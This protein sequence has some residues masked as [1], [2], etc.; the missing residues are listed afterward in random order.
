MARRR[1]DGLVQPRVCES[2]TGGAR[3]SGVCHREYGSVEP[4]P[5]PLGRYTTTHIPQ[6]QRLNNGTRPRKSTAA[7]LLSP[8]SDSPQPHRHPLHHA[9]SVDAPP[10]PISPPALPPPSPPPPRSHHHKQRRLLGNT[11]ARRFRLDALGAAAAVGGDVWVVRGA[12]EGEGGGFW[13]GRGGV[14]R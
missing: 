2:V 14:G 8:R 5:S 7:T 11:N 9:F 6:L 13:G 4:R 1:W 12:G 3:T 10:T